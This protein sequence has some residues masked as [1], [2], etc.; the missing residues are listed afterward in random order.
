MKR[1]YILMVAL[2]CAVAAGFVFFIARNTSEKQATAQPPKPALKGEQI[3]AALGVMFAKSWAGIKQSRLEGGG[4]GD[5]FHMTKEEINELRSLVASNP[6]VVILA[7]KGKFTEMVDEDLREHPDRHP[8][9]N[10]A[11]HRVGW[12]DNNHFGHTL[13]I[14]EMRAA[15][16]ES[17]GKYDFDGDIEWYFGDELKVEFPEYTFDFGPNFNKYFSHGDRPTT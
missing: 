16:P 9:E 8:A 17:Y 14:S 6:R 13:F 2:F 15:E 11:Q 5:N 1:E 7:L 12:Y 3:R 10:W 4:S